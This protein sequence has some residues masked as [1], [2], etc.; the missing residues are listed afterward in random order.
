MGAEDNSRNGK[1]KV[2]EL[3]GP[4]GA[5]RSTVVKSRLS[6]SEYGETQVSAR[7]TSVTSLIYKERARTWATSQAVSGKK[8]GP[9]PEIEEKPGDRKSAGPTLRSL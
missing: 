1:R 7:R 6:P 2:R 9:R 8:K 3:C 5:R 4:D